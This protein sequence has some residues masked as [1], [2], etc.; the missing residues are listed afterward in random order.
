M[1]RKKII[2]LF[3]LLTATFVCGTGLLYV[4]SVECKE[5]PCENRATNLAREGRLD[6]GIDALNQCI[7]EKPPSAKSHVAL[8]FLYLEKDNLQQ[9]LMSF[10]KALDLRPMS[11]GAKIGKGIVLSKNGDLKAAEAILQ[12]GLK[13]NPEPSRAHYELGLIYEQQ[14]NMEQAL[15][16][17]KKGISTYEKNNR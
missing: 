17:F 3:S 14:A 5:M 13:L 7:K 2:L 16:H 4:S 11:S 15:L 10:N 12:D 9:A 1:N 8:G 6:E